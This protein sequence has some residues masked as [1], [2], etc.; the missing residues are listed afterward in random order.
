MP[1]IYSGSLLSCCFQKNMKETLD[2]D[3]V[4][5]FLC[6]AVRSLN[7]R[8]FHQELVENKTGL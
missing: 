5:D 4:R 1:I 8:H 2:T 6:G 7:G 3:T